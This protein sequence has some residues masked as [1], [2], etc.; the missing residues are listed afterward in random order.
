MNIDVYLKHCSDVEL[1]Q[2]KDKVDKHFFHIRRINTQKRVVDTDM[3]GRVIGALIYSDFETINQV[4]QL[5]LFQLSK[6][7]GIGEKAIIEI[8]DM[9]EQH[10]LSLKSH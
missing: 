7:Q 3:S 6:V 1:G 9:L 8:I 5:N 10:G 4:A 2:L